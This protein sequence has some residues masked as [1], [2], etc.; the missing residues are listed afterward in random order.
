VIGLHLSDPFRRP[1]GGRPSRT[2]APASGS[3]RDVAVERDTLQITRVEPRH[4]PSDT[5][6]GV[7]GL[8]TS[9]RHRV[10]LGPFALLPIVRR[11]SSRC[12]SSRKG[13]DLR[14]C[15]P[16]LPMTADATRRLGSRTSTERSSRLPL[17]AAMI[18]STCS[19]C[20]SAVRRSAFRVPCARPRT[21]GRDLLLADQRLLQ[22]HRLRLRLGLGGGGGGAARRGLGWYSAPILNSPAAPAGAAA[23]PVQAGLAS[24]ASSSVVRRSSRTWLITTSS[25]SSA[26]SG[27]HTTRSRRPASSGSGA[28]IRGS[29]S[30]CGGRGPAED[31]GGVPRSLA[32]PSISAAGMPTMV[33]AALRTPPARGRRTGTAAGRGDRPCVGARHPGRRA[34]AAPSDSAPAKLLDERIGCAA[35]G[36]LPRRASAALRRPDL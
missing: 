13:L 2:S 30:R 15:E 17:R 27:R 35:L 22:R 7:R 28:A 21:S 23:V 19:S 31:P 25:A 9:S 24:S 1:A 8:R 3:P 26:G 10:A 11:I 20:R 4:Q 6:S 34:G 36:H 14:L 16:G 29:R 5:A 18:F 33:A 32:M 12:S